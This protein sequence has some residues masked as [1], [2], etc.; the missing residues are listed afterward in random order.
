MHFTYWKW[1]CQKIISCIDL[2]NIKISKSN[3]K[4]WLNDAFCG[5]RDPQGYHCFWRES[6]AS[7][8]NCSLWLYLNLVWLFLLNQRVPRKLGLQFLCPGKVAKH[9]KLPW[10]LESQMVINILNPLPKYADADWSFSAKDLF[11][12]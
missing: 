11:F 4:T 6:L 8:W 12:P 3:S 5:L 2:C 1:L 9:K 10:G 7:L